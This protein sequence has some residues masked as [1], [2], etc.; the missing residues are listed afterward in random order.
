[1]KRIDGDKEL[2][3]SERAKSEGL[4]RIPRR[5]RLE[6]GEAKKSP[7][8]VRVTM[9]LDSDVLEHFKKKAAEPNA[10]PYQTQINNELRKVIGAD[11][12]SY[13]TVLLNEVVSN[14]TLMSCISTEVVKEIVSVA[15]RSQASDFGAFLEEL[16]KNMQRCIEHKP[17]GAASA[18]NP[19][20]SR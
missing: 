18:R 17:L 4:K 10:A 7:C 2:I 9:Y 14:Q 12:S 19:E 13:W 15:Y 16:Q 8:K 5:H 11:Q 20:W 1:M 3:T 6:K